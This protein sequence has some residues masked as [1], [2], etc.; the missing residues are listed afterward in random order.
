MDAQQRITRFEF[1]RLVGRS[2]LTRVAGVLAGGGVVAFIV[3]KAWENR[4]L[5]AVVA[6]VLAL[7]VVVHAVG[8]VLA[9]ERRRRAL[10]GESRL[11]R[12]HWSYAY[13]GLMASGFGLAAGHLV[14]FYSANRDPVE[15]MILGGVFALAGL[16][17]QVAWLTWRTGA[18]AQRGNRAGGR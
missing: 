18:G 11:T 9:D 13:R 5:L 2:R 17:A 6:A 4:G 14:A 7:I 12:S 1:L 10:D 16:V 8:Y 3:V 15:G